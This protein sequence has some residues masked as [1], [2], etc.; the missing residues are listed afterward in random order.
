MCAYTA[1]RGALEAA[2]DSYMPLTVLFDNEETGSGTKQGALSDFLPVITARI[3]AA[4][5]MD[6]EEKAM[7][8][9]S[10]F[11]ISADNCHAL[12]P[13]SPEK[14]D[15][16]NKPR[17]NG[18]VAIK[19]SAAQKYTTD[20]ASASTLRLLLEKEGIPY[21]YFANNSDIP[22]GSTLGNLSAQKFSIPTVDIGAAQL[23]M[24]SPYE[25]AGT[26]DTEALLRMFS[27][28]LA[29]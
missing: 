12:H 3:E 18:G 8:A 17:M 26:K 22:G 2:G 11:M 7:A 16:T 24:H 23:A 9:A 6:E 13:D 20:A 4:L 10:S 27:A 25:T 28:F 15:I 14:C 21:Q 29:R 1:F 19:F 5:G